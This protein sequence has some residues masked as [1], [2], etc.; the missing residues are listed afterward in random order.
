[1]IRLRHFIWILVL[2]FSLPVQP[3]TTVK[4][5]VLQGFW[6]DYRHNNY[7]NSWANY[8][9]ELA[10]RLRQMGIDAVWIPPSIKK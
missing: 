9:T 6:W 1:M 3:Q 10:P 2:F 4:K 7:P 5:V 8:L